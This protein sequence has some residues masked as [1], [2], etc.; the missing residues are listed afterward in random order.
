MFTARIVSIETMSSNLTYNTTINGTATSFAGVAGSSFS[1]DS[2]A[3]VSVDSISSVNSTAGTT[4]S[5]T[6]GPATHSSSFAT[7]GFTFLPFPPFFTTT[8]VTVTLTFFSGFGTT[9]S[10]VSSSSSFSNPMGNTINSQSRPPPVTG[11][12]VRSFV[13]VGY[14]TGTTTQ[15]DTTMVGTDVTTTVNTITFTGSVTTS[16][17]TTNI[18]QNGRLFDA[19]VVNFTMT[20]Y[21]GFLNKISAQLALVLVPQPAFYSTTANA[22][23]FTTLTQGDDLLWIATTTTTNPYDIFSNFGTTTSGKTISFKSV[24]T[25]ITGTATTVTTTTSFADGSG[26]PIAYESNWIASKA[27]SLVIDKTVAQ[28]IT[29]NLTTVVSTVTTTIINGD[30]TLPFPNSSSVSGT[31][32]V[33]TTSTGTTTVHSITQST[34]LLSTTAGGGGGLFFTANF[35][36]VIDRMTVSTSTNLTR[37]VTAVSFFS[38]GDVYFDL[39]ASGVITTTEG[40]STTLISSITN[41]L[42]ILNGSGSSISLTSNSVDITRSVTKFSSFTMEFGGVS[43]A[44]DSFVSMPTALSA[45]VFAAGHEASEGSNLSRF[46]G[47][48]MEGF[49]PASACAVTDP[50]YTRVHFSVPTVS[51]PLWERTTT[52]VTTTGTTTSAS[53]TTS[54]QVGNETFSTI[55]DT[56]ISLEHSVGTTNTFISSKTGVAVFM[57]YTYTQSQSS[58]RSFASDGITYNGTT[59][60]YGASPFVI[61]ET[62][63][64]SVKGDSIFVT[65]S[66]PAIFTTN[67]AGP[68]YYTS[69]GR[70]N[71]AS[72]ITTTSFSVLIGFSASDSISASTSYKKM[73]ADDGYPRSDLDRFVMG[74][75]AQVSTVGDFARIGVGAYLY[76]VKP[77]TGGTPT[78]GLLFISDS[79]GTYIGHTGTSGQVFT[80]FFS[81]FNFISIASS[82]I[83][84]IEPCTAFRANLSTQNA[85]SFSDFS[86]PTFMSRGLFVISKNHNV[87]PPGIPAVGDILGGW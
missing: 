25:G 75:F 27:I 37:A 49:R 43:Q 70:V 44:L 63:V 35:A 54:T 3:F 24:A 78:T 41:S 34:V 84:N 11:T 50:I 36:A 68:R 47:V 77:R 9:T 86:V 76:T 42:A 87:F 79:V 14:T 66:G 45:N 61:F 72:F 31:A 46:V 12:S 8:A 4:R 30:T 65:V 32:T 13:S 19:G 82:L 74:G 83:M 38:V 6:V 16:Q 29:Y 5:T 20:Y 53:T 60:A 1:R 21:G 22:P 40:Y 71:P 23:G 28:T 7:T 52:S 59:P 33:G 57:S 62:S 85:A 81:S 48:F 15:I 39:H 18:T 55:P 69:D 80:V 2:A 64:S 10:S 56:N 51:I 17:Q 67:D 58:S 73:A 26:N